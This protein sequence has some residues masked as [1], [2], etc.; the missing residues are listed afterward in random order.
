MIGPALLSKAEAYGLAKAMA[1]FVMAPGLSLFIA[2]PGLIFLSAI[3]MLSAILILDGK[4]RRIL[5]IR[6]EF[7]FYY[8]LLFFIYI[9]LGALHRLDLM[10]AGFAG[11]IFVAVF[12]ISS[13]GLVKKWKELSS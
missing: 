6:K 1:F 7:I 8:S 2:G 12:I 4:L 10:R 5:R 9:M 11:T 13:I 3:L